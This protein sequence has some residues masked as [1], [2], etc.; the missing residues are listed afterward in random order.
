MEKVDRLGWAAQSTFR[1]GRFYVGVRSN[2]GEVDAALRR[3]LHRHLSYSIAAERNFSVRVRERE[4]AGV[5]QSQLLFQGC[6]T[7][8]RARRA[9]QVIDD[10]LRRLDAHARADDDALL[11]LELPAVIKHGRAIVL[12]AWVGRAPRELDRLQ[13]AGFVPVAGG[14]TYIDPSLGQL[15]VPSLAL[16]IDEREVEWWYGRFDDGRPST[17]RVEIGAYPIAAWLFRERQP[18]QT[19]SSAAA[20][21]EVV[22]YVTNAHRVGEQRALVG[23]VGAL[24]SAR[25]AVLPRSSD[26]AEFVRETCRRDGG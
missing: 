1:I 19:L 25:L 21:P 23:L 24:K 22:R 9:G 10:L 6:T 11:R 16:D 7:V 4:P 5:D 12:P 2:K 8:L 18:G 17:P 20:L 26:V 13:R 3:I 15:R 14:D